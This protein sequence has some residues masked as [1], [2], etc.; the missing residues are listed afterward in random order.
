MGCGRTVAPSTEKRKSPYSQP[1]GA[2]ETK[3]FAARNVSPS[4]LS[5]RQ[6]THSISLHAEKECPYAHIAWADWAKNEKR[7]RGKLQTGVFALDKPRQPAL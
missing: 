2:A 6:H 3:S 5:A 7:M 1:I 4:F